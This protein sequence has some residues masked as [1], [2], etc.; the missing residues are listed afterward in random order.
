MLEP[1]FE[2]QVACCVC[3]IN[4]TDTPI[5]KYEIMMLTQGLGMCVKCQLINTHD[6]LLS[7]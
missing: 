1:F 7:L 3:H 6:L 4:D 5:C 2:K